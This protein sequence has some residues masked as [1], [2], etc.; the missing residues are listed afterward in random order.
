MGQMKY[1]I[2]A[3]VPER[4]NAVHYFASRLISGDVKDWRLLHNMSERAVLRL[5][6]DLV[7][8]Q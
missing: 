6:N 4:G 2:K 5:I 8:A 7:A 1:A 3:N